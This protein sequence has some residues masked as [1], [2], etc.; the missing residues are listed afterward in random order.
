MCAFKRAEAAH[1]TNYTHY[2][3]E[4]IKKCSAQGARNETT[5]EN[6]DTES[7][8]KKISSRKEYRASHTSFYKK[9]KQKKKKHNNNTK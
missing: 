2:H 9:Q 4:L 5:E 6:K 1:T 3:Y 7:K 8:T